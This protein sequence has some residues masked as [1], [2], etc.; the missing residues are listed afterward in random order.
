MPKFQVQ[1]KK[2]LNVAEDTTA[3]YFEKPLGFEFKAGQN[4]DWTIE[5]LPNPDAKGNTRPFSIASAPHEPELMIATRM[6]KSTFKDYLAIAEPGLEL[7]LDGPL[8]SFTLHNNPEKP[9]VFLIGGIGITPV[10]SIIADAIHRKLPHQLILFY[11][12]RRSED[13]AFLDELTAWQQDNQ[14]FKLVATMT[15]MDK[16]SQTWLGATGYVDAKMLQE[17]LGDKL[18]TA[19]YYLAGP[20]AMVAAMRKVLDELNID[21]DNIKTEEFSGY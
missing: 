10:R 18:S 16:S 8:G 12:N 13:T 2:K 4:A 15:E 14:N 1:L 5:N 3:F 19:I 20:P 6:T 11:S 21:S 17:N 7:V 9:A